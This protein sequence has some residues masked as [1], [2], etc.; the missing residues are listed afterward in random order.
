MNDHIETIGAALAGIAT[1]V[2]GVFKLRPK[3]PPKKDTPEMEA[4]RRD[5]REQVERVVRL[6]TITDGVQEQIRDLRDELR[7]YRKENSES[8]EKIMTK[9]D[10]L[11]NRLSILKG[12]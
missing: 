10:G 3:S 6:E 2:A 11:N 4:L 1:G 7:T 12:R 5:V 9:L 8:D